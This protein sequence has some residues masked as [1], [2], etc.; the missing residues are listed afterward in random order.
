MGTDDV[1]R[2]RRRRVDTGD[3]HRSRERALRVVFQA[4]LRGIR[5]DQLLR[6]LGEDDDARSLLDATDEMVDVPTVDQTVDRAALRRQA[7]LDARAGTT[8]QPRTTVPRIDGFT[9]ALVLG[10]ADHADEI[11]ALI[12]RFARRWSIPRMPVVDRSVLRLATYELLYEPTPP[13]VVINEAV[14]LAKT[15]STDDSGAY[16]NGVLESIRRELAAQR[17]D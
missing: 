12:T 14:E 5:P 15:L 11:D 2:S 10:V 16:V 17:D 8:E 4:E 7:E 3:P 13:A 9:R 1:A 6:S